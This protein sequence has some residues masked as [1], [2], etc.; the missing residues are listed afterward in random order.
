MLVQ[1][2]FFSFGNFLESQS[3]GDEHPLVGRI[4]VSSCVLSLFAAL[5]KRL[6]KY[7][8]AWSIHWKNI[9]VARRIPACCNHNGRRPVVIIFVHTETPTRKNGRIKKSVKPAVVANPETVIE[10]CG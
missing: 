7:L 9:P 1:L 2:F 4:P 3:H 8:K 10:R 5:S 6:V